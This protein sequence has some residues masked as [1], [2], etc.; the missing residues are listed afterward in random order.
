MYFWWLFGQ[1][2]LVWQ[3]SSCLY[4]FSVHNYVFCLE[5]GKHESTRALNIK[6]NDATGLT[7][8]L[9]VI[10]MNLPVEVYL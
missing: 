10:S 6:Y 2:D 8:V 4:V 3:G 7:G 5:P 9:V 1:F